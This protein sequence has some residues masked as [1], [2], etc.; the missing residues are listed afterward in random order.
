MATYTPSRGDVIWLDF[1]STSGHEQAGHRP[2][3]V[4]SGQRYNQKSGLMLACPITTKAKGYP[5]E[6]K[7]TAGVI[8]GVVLSDQIKSLDWQRRPIKF[9]AKASAAAVKRCQLLIRALLED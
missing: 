5:F 1:G 2:A 8:D 6:A 3:L 9:E 4:L 7:V